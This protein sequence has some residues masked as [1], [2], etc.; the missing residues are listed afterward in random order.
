MKSLTADFAPGVAIWRP[1]P[2]NVVWRP[3]GAATWRAGRYIPVICDSGLP[4]ENVTS[5]TKLKFSQRI[6]KRTETRPQITCS[7]N[8]V[9]FGRV[10]FLD[11]RADRQ[12]NRQ[13]DRHADQNNNYSNPAG[14]DVISHYTCG[15]NIL[16]Y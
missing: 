16:A 1:R 12:S 8:L 11:M 2:N 14:G 4:C 6:R 5:S 15:K 10:V 7:A 13:T 3:N 9:K